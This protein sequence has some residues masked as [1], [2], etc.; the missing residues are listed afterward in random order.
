LEENR[1]EREAY[2]NIARYCDT[3][4]NND[5]E[6]K[7]NALEYAEMALEKFPT[8]HVVIEF[9]ARM[10]VERGDKEH[11]ED[12][13]EEALERE[14]DD[15]DYWLAMGGIARD[16]WPLR[17]ERNRERVMGVYEK[18]LRSDPT[19]LDMVEQ[20]AQFF[21]SAGS[22]ERALQIYQALVLRS[23]DRLSARKDL[24][25]LFWQAGQQDEAIAGLEKLVQINPGAI[26]VHRM[27][28]EMYLAQKDLKRATQHSETIVE[29]GQ[30]RIDDYRRLADFQRVG[31]RVGGALQT[32]RQGV[33]VFPDSPELSHSLGMLYLGLD[34]Y[35]EAFSAL[36]TAEG[37]ADAAGR[38][39]FLTEAFYFDFAV[40]AERSG[41]IERAEEL[42]R[43]SIDL[44]SDDANEDKAKSLNYIGYM[45]LELEKNLD[46][47]GEMIKKAN[48]LKPDNGAYLDSLG[49]Y[50][51]LKE[52]Y[53]EAIKHLLR[54]EELMAEDAQEDSVIYEH[55]AR[56]YLGKGDRDQARRFCERALGIEPDKA[57]L[58][59]LRELIE[60][61]E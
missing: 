30:A 46:E 50:Y 31:D 21:R 16:V 6:L 23:P 45:W 42:F 17:N 44:V 59:E 24:A 9:L 60:K 4:H 18:A 39:D 12:V 37:Q 58:K 55:L 33:A 47:A 25:E 53:D 20:V 13:L 27:L 19:N 3:H 52:D 29:S 51:Y 48:E 43:K 26:E 1:S 57:E 11:A 35:A 38:S 54:A 34:R 22:T 49:W 28:S 61:G 36:E 2:L 5:D 40:S 15:G 56:A 8:D 41:E 32:L 10:L 7:Q 14:V